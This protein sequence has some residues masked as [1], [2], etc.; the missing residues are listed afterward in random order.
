[1]YRRPPPQSPKVWDLGVGR[2]SW[3]RE[4]TLHIYTTTNWQLSPALLLQWWIHHN[5]VEVA[6][7][8]NLSGANTNFDLAKSDRH[9]HTHT[10]SSCQSYWQLKQG[11]ESANNTFRMN[12]LDQMLQRSRLDS[13]EW[14]VV[15]VTAA[16]LTHTH[17]HI[18]S[19]TWI[20]YYFYYQFTCQL[21]CMILTRWNL[22]T[23]WL[24]KCFRT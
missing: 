12:D 15:Q 18:T 9:R 2:S 10:H 20:Q 16:A 5:N 8:W 1:M 4:P 23:N 13:A 6:P 7:H 24:I 3:L 14:N 19:V 17:T 21:T 11:R 22:L